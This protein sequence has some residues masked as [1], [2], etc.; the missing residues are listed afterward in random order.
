MVEVR[1]FLFQQGEV[2]FAFVRIAVIDNDNLKLRIILFQYSGQ[3]A[4]QV[5]GFFTGADDDRYRGE[6][7]GKVHIVSFHG[8]AAHVNTVV[9]TKVIKGLNDKKSS[10]R[11]E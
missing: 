5:L 2:I 7:L 11:C 3:I 1:V 6:L 8:T 10:R 9:Q 4:A